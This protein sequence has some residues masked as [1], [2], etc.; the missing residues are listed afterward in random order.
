MIILS[1]D[2]ILVNSYF[3]YYYIP[4][5]STDSVFF[6]AQTMLAFRNAIGVALY[7]MVHD[8]ERSMQKMAAMERTAAAIVVDLPEDAYDPSEGRIFSGLEH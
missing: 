1:K 3:K 8:V 5:S 6:D 2:E 7:D 4:T